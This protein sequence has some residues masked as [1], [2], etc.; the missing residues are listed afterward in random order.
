MFDEIE[1]RT[2]KTDNVLT[3]KLFVNQRK[4]RFMQDGARPHI[5]KDTM[6]LLKKHKKVFKYGFSSIF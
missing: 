5:A 1:S 3:T 2:R 6:A 4:A